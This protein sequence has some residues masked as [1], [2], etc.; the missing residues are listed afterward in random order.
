MEARFGEASAS[1]AARDML[2]W[3]LLPVAAH[4]SFSAEYDDKKPLKLKGKV[5]R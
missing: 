2:A 1:I 3:A 4:H 5:T